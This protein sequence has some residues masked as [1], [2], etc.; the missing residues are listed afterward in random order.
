MAD[1]GVEDEE[2]LRGVIEIG[3][4]NKRHKKYFE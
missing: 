1:I 3:L 2:Q 4:R